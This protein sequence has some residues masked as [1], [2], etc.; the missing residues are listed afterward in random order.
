MISS[1]NPKTLE[2][3]IRR[4]VDLSG[5]MDRNGFVLMR[6]FVCY[7]VT[8]ELCRELETVRFSVHKLV[9]QEGGGL[10]LSEVIVGRRIRSLYRAV[11]ERR[12]REEIRRVFERIQD[13]AQRIGVERFVSAKSYIFPLLHQRASGRFRIG[14]K[15][16]V[17]SALVAD[18]LVGRL[19]G[20]LIRR[21]ARVCG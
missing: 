19:D 18:R 11:R 9:S 3:D 1:L 16:D 2:R 6:L 14:V 10:N 4:V 17:F 12:S 20:Y 7:A 13:R 15:R 21:L 8:F 5:W